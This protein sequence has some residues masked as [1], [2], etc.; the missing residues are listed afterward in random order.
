MN[1]NIYL[2]KNKG[3]KMRI[4]HYALGFPPYRT[5]G[6]TKFCMDLL[7]QQ[8]KAGHHVAMMWPGK[9]SLFSKNTQIRNRGT[10]VLDGKKTEIGSFEVIN[11]LPVSYDE[12]ISNISAFTKNVDEQVY[13][14]FI[15]TYKPDVVHVHTLMGLH[16]SFLTAVKKEGARLVFSAHDFFPICPKVTLF[17]QGNIC[18]SIHSCRDCGVCNTTALS[19]RKISIL[20][21][22]VY[23]GLK[24]TSLVKRLRKQHRDA[25]LSGGT[26]ARDAEPVGSAADFMRLREYYH[27]LLQMMDIIHYNS[28]VTKATYESVFQLP[29]SCVINITH[30]DIRDNRKNKEFPAMIFRIRYL[31]PAGEG[32]G[33]FYSRR[34]LISY[35]V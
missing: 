10:V 11:P 31:G 9:I 17:R 14:D 5:G 3:D 15:C 25:Y 27:S 19:L 16:K 28:T 23:Q 8:D 2:I 26:S 33:F 20:Q 21:S 24:N 22:P 32:K 12:G 1:S 6:L 7:Q 30:A 18:L 35:G 29:N 34:H 13:T 4:L